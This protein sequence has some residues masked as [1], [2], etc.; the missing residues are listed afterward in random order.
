MQKIDIKIF[1]YLYKIVTLT[2]SKKFVAVG[3][4]CYAYILWFRYG[5]VNFI[6]ALRLELLGEVKRLQVS[7]LPTPK[8]GGGVVTLY[9]QNTLGVSGDVAYTCETAGHFYLYQ[10]LSRWEA[11]MSKV[12]PLADTVSEGDKPHK[13][14]ICFIYVHGNSMYLVVYFAWHYG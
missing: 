3:S 7:V 11:Y 8:G 5:R 13:L 9:V 1:I 4:C 10:V 12:K 6:L 2:H 14:T